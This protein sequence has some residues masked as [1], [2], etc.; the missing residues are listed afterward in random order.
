M[1]F[2]DALGNTLKNNGVVIDLLK[3]NPTILAS[4]KVDA[5]GN[6]TAAT[7]TIN[8]IVISS[9]ILPLLKTAKKLIF[10]TSIGTANGAANKSV[11]LRDDYTIG[12]KLGVN[13]QAGIKK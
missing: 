6:V 10:K 7:T 8:D 5:N 12:F 13:I 9:E 4:G 1:Y 3:L 11:K 2:V